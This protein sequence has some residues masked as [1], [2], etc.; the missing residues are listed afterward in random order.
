ME[1][2]CWDDVRNCVS[3]IKNTY[4]KGGTRIRIEISLSD[5]LKVSTS[6]GKNLQSLVRC[7]SILRIP[8]LKN[9]LKVLR[10]LLEIQGLQETV[11]TPHAMAVLD[12]RSFRILERWKR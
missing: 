11:I 8:I 1:R 12:A 10:T 2:E 7:G 4:G 9:V 5:F 6:W 3:G